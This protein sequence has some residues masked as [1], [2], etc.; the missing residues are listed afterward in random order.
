M[1]FSIIFVLFFVN[2]CASNDFECGYSD[3]EMES[4]EFYCTNFDGTTPVNCSM[5]FY[6]T[7]ES[8][9]KSKVTHLKAGGCGDDRISWLVDEI[10]NLRSLDISHSGIVSL[11]TLNLTSGQLKKVNASYNRLSE[12]SRSFF[13]HIPNVTEVDF[14]HNHL[15]GI[16]DLP[17]SLNYIDLSL[18]LI[19]I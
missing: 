9:N 7:L 15:H 14:S 13:A 18:S 4:I 16:I 5:A 1:C 6:F 2:F 10:P 8:Y 17:D 12:I 3:D 11:D 19:H